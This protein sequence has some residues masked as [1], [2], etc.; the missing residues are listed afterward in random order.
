MV[1]FIACSQEE[2]EINTFVLDPSKL[3][4][5]GANVTEVRK[6]LKITD[7]QKTPKLTLGQLQGFLRHHRVE[8]VS[9]VGGTARVWCLKMDEIDGALVVCSQPAQTIESRSVVLHDKKND[10]ENS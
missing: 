8:G 5:T 10:G 1:G 9:H 3:T 7:E 2:G 6:K 4:G